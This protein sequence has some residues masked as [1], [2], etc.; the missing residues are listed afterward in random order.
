MSTAEAIDT[1]ADCVRESRDLR[2][3]I[4]RHPELGFEEF[5]TS[6]LVAS[7]LA[8]W[9]YQVTR[10]L[11]GTGLVGQLRAGGS[12]RSIGLRA[13]L[14]AL[15]IQEATGLPHASEV[16]GLMHGC[17]HDGHTAMLLGAAKYLADTRNFSG[18]VNLIF[19]PAEETLI[20]ARK[21]LDDHLFERFPCDAIFAMHNMPGFEEGKLVFLP[22]PLM[23]SSDRATVTVI[24]R[25]GHGALPHKAVDPIVVAASMV[26]ALQ[27]IV[28]RTV[29]P[30]DP[31]VVT[32]GSLKG[33]EV[34][35][36]I[37]ERATLQITIRAL[38]PGTRDLL[39]QSIRRIVAAQAA[40]YGAQ[41]EI[42]YVRLCPVLVNHERETGIARS[43][44]ESLF[45]AGEL[46]DDALPLMGSEDFAHM[47]QQCPG[48]Y[49]LIG[50]GKGPGAPSVHNPGYDFND[51]CL[52]R[53]V[54]FWARLVEAWLPAA[55]R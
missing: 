27:T 4:H 36:V 12:S 41:A 11:G 48:S 55:G 53:G 32:V 51:R 24:G 20:G 28:S 23:A 16:P 1:F 10:G 19:Q 33:G 31:A 14:D 38:R 54:A 15:P 46:V 21:M 35:N 50:N 26:M 29:D 17:G 39:E 13:D 30:Q 2:H 6:D 40:C 52:P 37:P 18:T 45:G 5:Q 49:V 44:A 43:L 9:G 42:E 3:R 22:G 47:L 34:A 7:C 25:G 8:G